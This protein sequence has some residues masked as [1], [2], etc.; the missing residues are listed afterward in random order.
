LLI[1][2][3]SSLIL[4][5]CMQK[6]DLSY[7]GRNFLFRS[8]PRSQLPASGFVLLL[9]IVFS[10][11]QP[12]TVGGVFGHVVTS[13]CWPLR[14]LRTWLLPRLKCD[15]WMSGS[16]ASWTTRSILRNGQP[17]VKYTV[18]MVVTIVIPLNKWVE[19]KRFIC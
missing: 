5:S 14:F 6:R 3:Y 7:V 17:H 13:C 15:L 2:C 19:Q 11:K 9:Q 12:V 1:V 8:P 10:S 4:L 18:Y 16:I